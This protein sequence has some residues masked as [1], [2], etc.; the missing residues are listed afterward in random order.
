[1]YASHLH[2]TGLSAEVE[3][4]KTQLDAATAAHAAAAAQLKAKRAR[5][6]DCDAE[7]KGLEKELGRIRKAMQDLEVEKKRR[8]S[9]YVSYIHDV[10]C[11]CVLQNPR[12]IDGMYGCRWCM[13]VVY[14]KC[15]TH[16]NAEA[17]TCVHVAAAVVWQVGGE[18]PGVWWQ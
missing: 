10:I 2:P 8:E 6:A 9:K 11:I 7:I 1:M 14:C 5:L 3:V 15:A 16:C 13:H 12:W 18:A 4:L 17:V